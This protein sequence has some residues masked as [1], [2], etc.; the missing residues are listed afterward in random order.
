MPMKN[1]SKGA[2]IL[3][4]F[5]IHDT[6]N[7]EE[8][9]TAKIDRREKIFRIHTQYFRATVPQSTTTQATMQAKERKK[10][11]GNNMNLLKGK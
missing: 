10:K 7:D 6:K 11:S 3:D 8:K 1:Y 2:V 5:N 9:K 4:I